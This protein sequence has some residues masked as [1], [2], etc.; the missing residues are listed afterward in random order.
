MSPSLLYQNLKL[1]VKSYSPL[2]VDS[3]SILIHSFIKAAVPAQ[4]ILAKHDYR[5]MRR[6]LASACSNI[7]LKDKKVSF[8]WK[9]EYKL[10]VK[11]PKSYTAKRFYKMA[12]TYFYKTHVEG[13]NLPASKFAP[14][15]C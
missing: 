11:R 4:K 12:R 9:N 6:R 14:S 1:V 8:I 7:F 5:R 15:K 2:L 3:R 10:L 13:A